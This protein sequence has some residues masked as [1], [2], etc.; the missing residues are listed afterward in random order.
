ML[1]CTDGVLE[2]NGCQANIEKGGEGN[3]QNQKRAG[4]FYFAVFNGTLLRLKHNHFQR[5]AACRFA[6]CVASLCG[7]VVAC[8]PRRHLFVLGGFFFAEPGTLGTRTNDQVARALDGKGHATARWRQSRAHLL[9]PPCGL[10]CPDPAA[11]WRRSG[12]VDCQARLRN[13]GVSIPLSTYHDASDPAADVGPCPRSW[14]CPVLS[15]LVL[16]CPVLSCPV[17]SCPILSCPSLSGPVVSCP[18]LSCPI[19]SCPV[20]SFL[21]SFSPAMA[22][23]CMNQLHNTIW[24][25]IILAV[26]V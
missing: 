1:H 25:S 22:C 15:C 5:P 11:R 13:R 8:M 14:S 4:G 20:L 18:G 26:P 21:V 17:L 9:A 3:K 2:L 24:F 6:F 16:S 19:V 10:S 7:T 12:L 23:L